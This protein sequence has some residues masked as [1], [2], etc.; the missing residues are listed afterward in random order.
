MP[1][2][3]NL[4]LFLF[5]TFLFWRVLNWSW[6]LFVRVAFSNQRNIVGKGQEPDIHAN[7]H[8]RSEQNQSRLDSVRAARNRSFPASNSVT[9]TES[10]P[11]SNSKTDANPVRQHK[12]P[13]TKQGFLAQAKD[14]NSPLNS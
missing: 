11:L 4:P 5:A 9:S 8:A 10:K 2:I 7:G 14:Q 1:I 12:Y 13:A 3:I 6:A